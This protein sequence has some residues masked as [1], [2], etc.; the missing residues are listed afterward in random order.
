MADQEE[1]ARKKNRNPS[2]LSATAVIKRVQK[3]E[4]TKDAPALVEEQTNE[5]F[6]DVL[7]A[8]AT[9]NCTNPRALARL[10]VSVNNLK[11]GNT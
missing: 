1:I 3:I 7:Y 4:D 2:F 9:G 6:K 5:L 11:N 8:I 10:A